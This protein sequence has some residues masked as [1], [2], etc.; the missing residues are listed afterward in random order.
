MLDMSSPSISPPQSAKLSSETS[1]LQVHF[2]TQSE[3]LSEKGNI[4]FP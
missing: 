2:T 4:Y 3:M 1:V